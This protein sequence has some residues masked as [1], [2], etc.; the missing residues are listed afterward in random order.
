[1]DP[2]AKKSDLETEY[3][4]LSGDE[5]AEPDLYVPGKFDISMF[6]RLKHSQTAD[7]WRL[8]YQYN[9]YG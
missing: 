1:M 7:L 2:V 6:E 3:Y 8:I 5:Q 9:L 4:P